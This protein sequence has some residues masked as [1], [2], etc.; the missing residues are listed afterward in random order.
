MNGPLA[1]ALLMPTDGRKGNVAGIVGPPILFQL[2]ACAMRGLQS[3]QAMAVTSRLCLVH[4]TCSGAMWF[5]ACVHY[6]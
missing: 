2:L 5:K 4:L 3:L 6:A 1:R